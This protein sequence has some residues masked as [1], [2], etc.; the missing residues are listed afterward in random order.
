[1]IQEVMTAVYR[2]R[3]VPFK[4]GIDPG[5]SDHVAFGNAGIPYGWLFTGADA[6][7]TAEE[8]AVW[9]GKAGMPMDPCYHLTCDNL[10]NI[11]TVALA[12]N[13]DAIA[14]AALHFAMNRLPR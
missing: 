10:G 9:G 7:K 11:N 4:R 12:L 14:Y 3:G 1:M 13:A 6:I 5:L 8:V 2:Q